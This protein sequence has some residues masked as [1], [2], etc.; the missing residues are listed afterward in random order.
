MTNTIRTAA[1]FFC[2][3]SSDKEYNVYL[4]EGNGGYT[5]DFSYGRRG[6]ALK[7]GTKTANGPVSLE[8]AEKAYDKLVASKVK[9]GYTES[10]ND[11]PF[12]SGELGDRVTDFRPKLLNPI[13]YVELIAL[14]SSGSYLAQIKRDGER[15]G[16]IADQGGVIFAN[17]DG[18]STSASSTIEA[19]VSQMGLNDTILD[20]E[21]MGDH[22]Y[23]FD[24]L[25]VNGVDLL[26]RPFSQRIDALEVFRT[27][28]I[29]NQVEDT[30]RIDVPI[31][32]DD[33]ASFAELQREAGAEGIVICEAGSTYV[34]GRPASGGPALKFKFTETATFE[35]LR[36]NGTKRSVEIAI[37]TENGLRSVG[38]CTIPANHAIPSAG[39]PVDVEYLYAYPNGGLC[40]PVYKRPRND[41]TVDTESKLKFKS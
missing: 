10:A 38:N 36:R 22:V 35:V 4:K 29:A 5:V 33:M 26:D 19:A 7:S 32:V 14:F 30:L 21:D 41:V 20:C 25:R 3:G 27:E 12:I 2:A 40:Q 6:E 15:R 39:D 28:V 13:S 24:I 17:R 1:L 18:L 37:L 23:V 11:A 9:K 31:E 8:E 34:P 16:V